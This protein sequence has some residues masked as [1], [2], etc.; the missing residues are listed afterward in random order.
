MMLQF[1]QLVSPV[2]GT[3]GTSSAFY[4]WVAQG[5][6]TSLHGFPRSVVVFTEGTSAA[7]V[8]FYEVRSESSYRILRRFIDQHPTWEVSTEWTRGRFHWYLR[9]RLNQALPIFHFR[10]TRQGWVRVP[11]PRQAQVATSQ[12]ET[13]FIPQIS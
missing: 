2:A 1:S 5:K 7:P 12:E 4:P 8:V 3:G 9:E 6:S 11:E 10:E 13:L